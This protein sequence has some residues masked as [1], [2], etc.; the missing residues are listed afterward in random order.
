[1]T[2]LSE[3]NDAGVEQWN[4]EKEWYNGDKSK[5]NTLPEF[6]YEEYLQYLDPQ[7]GIDSAAV[8]GLVDGPV[9]ERTLKKRNPEAYARYQQFAKRLLAENKE[10]I[11]DYHLIR[12][13]EKMKTV[14]IIQHFMM[15]IYRA[16]TMAPY[17]ILILRS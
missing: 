3:K 5:P 7:A 16:F 13:A 2:I 8:M 10:F 1:M 6:T 4:K 14:S 9:T 17:R 12:R 11:E 15:P